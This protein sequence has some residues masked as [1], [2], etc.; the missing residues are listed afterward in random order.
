MFAETGHKHIFTT[1]FVR[2][3]AIQTGGQKVKWI[4]ADFSS[5]F[6]KHRCWILEQWSKQRIPAVVRRAVEVNKPTGN[7]FL[8]LCILSAS[9]PFNELGTRCDGH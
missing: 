7:Q 4:K 1:D 9:F 3:L 5:K 8:D 2:E 6:A